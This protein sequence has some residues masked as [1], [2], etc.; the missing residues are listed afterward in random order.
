MADDNA[1]TCEVGGTIAAGGSCSCTFT[2]NVPAGDF[3]GSFMDMVTACANNA[4]NPTPICD[5]DD[6]EVPYT[7][8]SLPPTLTK[9]AVNTQCRIDVTYNVVVTNGQRRR[10]DAEHADRQRVRRHHPGPGQHRQH[11]LWPATGAVRCRLTIAPAGN[12]TCSFVGRITSCNMTVTDTV[13]GDRD[14]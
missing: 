3:P 2:A 14:G 7:D 6:A 8:V 5:D 4:T 9:T 12:Y 1:A 11:D 13:T 10:A